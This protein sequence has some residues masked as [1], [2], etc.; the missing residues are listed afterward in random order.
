MEKIPIFR[1]K[2]KKQN[3]IQHWFCREQFWRQLALQ[4]ARIALPSNSTRNCTHRSTVSIYLCSTSIYAMLVS[5]LLCPK[6]T[7]SSLYTISVY[8]RFHRNALFSDIWEAYSFVFFFNVYLFIFG[9]LGS[10]LLHGLSSSRNE[11]GLLSSCGAR[12]SRCGSF[13]HRGAQALGPVGSVVMAQG[14]SCP[15]HLG[16]S[17]I[18]D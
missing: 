14:V 6:V 10:L 8:K 5:K 12:A 1:K 9:C 15:G 4:A 3:S 18:R 17:W 7:A 16:S 13:S 2:G 11:W